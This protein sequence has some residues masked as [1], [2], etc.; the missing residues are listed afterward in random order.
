TY[1]IAEGKQ[2]DVHSAYSGTAKV[3]AL[4]FSP[5]GEVAAL[6][7]DDGSVRVWDV[8]KKMTMPNGE[9]PAHQEKIADVLLA[10]GEQTIITPDV[11][12]QVKIWDL[13]NIKPGAQAEAIKSWKAHDQAANALAISPDGK[14]FATAGQDN[15]VK[16]WDVASGKA[17]RE[18]DFHMPKSLSNPIALVNAIVFTPDGKQLITSN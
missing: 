8:N 18:W 3:A 4:T 5:D 2:I 7:F 12:G 17:L 10:Q 1:D 16:L 14:R 15:V 9:F 13:K 11:K 6:G